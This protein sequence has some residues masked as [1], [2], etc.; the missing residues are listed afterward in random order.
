MKYLKHDR[1]CKS[2]MT[3]NL[4]QFSQLFPKILLDTDFQ[5][6]FRWKS[7]RC[8]E[9]FK[10]I[11]DGT[12]NV[13]IKINSI[14]A[15]IKHA[16]EVRCHESL[17]Y[18]KKAKKNGY[19]YVSLD[20]NSRA[21]WNALFVLGF[22]DTVL[23]SIKGK[24][25]S[26]KNK[27]YNLKVEWNPSDFKDY[28]WWETLS[29]MSKEENKIIQYPNFALY[30][31]S[32]KKSI[33]KSK[34]CKYVGNEKVKLNDNDTSNLIQ[35]FNDVTSKVKFEIEVW[36]KLTK[37]EQHKMFVNF[38][39][40]ESINGQDIRN[41]WNVDMSYYVRNISKSVL[42]T[43]E[44]NMKESDILKR[45]HHEMI[46]FCHMYQDNR[47]A[48]KL[49]KMT[50]KLLDLYWK[51]KVRESP[52]RRNMNAEETHIWT[53]FE[54][55]VKTRNRILESRAMFLDIFLISLWLHTNNIST[56]IIDE[57]RDED[58]V[59][60]IGWST[61][62]KLHADWMTSQHNMGNVY[63]V[64]K[65]KS[66]WNAFRGGIWAFTYGTQSEPNKWSESLWSYLDDKLKNQEN[67]ENSY[68]V[69]RKK[70]KDVNTI[71]IR[72]ILWWMQGQKCAATGKVI[73]ID[74]VLK[75]GRNSGGYEVDHRTSL[76]KG[77]SNDIGNL[78]LICA[79]KNG[80]KSNKI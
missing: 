24:S 43:I 59:E 33:T 2:G 27:K 18:F 74:D 32:S 65:G 62:M 31:I 80:E 12:G 38:N 72:T 11:M 61:I 48:L 66:D 69:P 37:S 73:P 17:E 57:L 9:Y 67:S 6:Y 50:P 23:K 39:L 36:T 7:S 44:N 20:G 58:G 13:H 77:G 14:D 78:Q 63:N 8:K 64:V 45:A 75:T 21:T 54:K 15:A 71:T 60:K 76:D 26:I 56:S 55:L 79:K 16:T 51:T 19:E 29:S 46:G 41:A 68:L 49:K 70:R 5:R 22:D 52:Y 3:L 53:I 47:T 35:M 28:P 4:L 40:N 1:V 34:L 42:E 10:S 25:S 30:N